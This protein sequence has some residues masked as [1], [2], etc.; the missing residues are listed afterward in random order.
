[1]QIHAKPMNKY[2]TISFKLSIMNAFLHNCYSYQCCR[3]VS[4]KVVARYKIIC[5]TMCS[6]F[7][8][9]K[10]SRF[11]KLILKSV[12]LFVQLCSGKTRL[13]KSLE[14]LIYCSDLSLSIYHLQVD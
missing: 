10:C 9:E 13:R 7:V 6:E 8:N 1:M 12:Y 2:I 11:F 3:A 5:T 4:H 14:E